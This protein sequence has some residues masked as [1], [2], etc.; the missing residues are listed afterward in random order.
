MAWWS[1]LNDNIRKKRNSWSLSLAKKEGWWRGESAVGIWEMSSVLEHTFSLKYGKKNSLKVRWKE[2]FS[3]SRGRNSLLHLP[4]NMRE[5]RCL[6]HIMASHFPRTI[7]WA[8]TGV[9]VMVEDCGAPWWMRYSPSTEE[10]VWRGQD[11]CSSKI[12]FSKN[13][14]WKVSLK[15]A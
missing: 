11:L 9:E 3:A 6:D 14:K 5:L 12:N 7:S 8:P 2:P 13:A 1:Q 10:A 15:E 4:W